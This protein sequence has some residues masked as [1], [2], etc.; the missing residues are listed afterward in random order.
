MLTEL[1]LVC[2]I[3]LL[4]KFGQA[5]SASAFAAALLTE[6]QTVYKSKKTLTGE[7]F[8]NWLSA[9]AEEFVCSE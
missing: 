2:Y 8:F 7:L 5:T 9:L 6:L 1:Q 3:N 4:Y